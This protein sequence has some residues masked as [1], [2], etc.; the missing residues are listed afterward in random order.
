MKKRRLICAFVFLVVICLVVVLVVQ[1]SKIVGEEGLIK[2]ARKEIKNLAEVETIEMTV[3]GKSTIDGNRH[4][5]W[6]ITGNEYQMHRYYP[7]EVIEVEN[8]KY[9]FVHMHNVSTERGQDIFFEYFG[10]GY[11]FIVNNP[12]CKGIVIGETTIPVT[13]IPFVYY[14]PFAPNE[15]Y[16]EYY[17]I[18]ENGTK[19]N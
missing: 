12:K 4:M 19:L 14:Y 17:F 13:E 5:F 2:R 9:K 8:E 1:S 3:A 6:I 10:S 7:L 11:S 16:F 15:Y 18:D